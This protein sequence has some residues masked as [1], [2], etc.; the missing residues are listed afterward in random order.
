MLPEEWCEI[1]GF[2]VIKQVGSLYLIVAVDGLTKH[3][4][5]GRWRS[6]SQG[7]SLLEMPFAGVLQRM[8][9]SFSYILHDTWKIQKYQH[10][11]PYLIISLPFSYQNVFF[12]QERYFSN[13]FPPMDRFFLHPVVVAG[14]LSAWEVIATY[15][16][17]ELVAIFLGDIFPARMCWTTPSVVKWDYRSELLSTFSWRIPRCSMGLAKLNL[18]NW[19]VL[20]GKW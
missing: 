16:I 4:G 7:P 10:F 3:E 5:A 14:L 17:R 13:H 1:F 8:P 12:L 6:L 9:K 11:Q 2:P 18:H 15:P 19:V 20:G